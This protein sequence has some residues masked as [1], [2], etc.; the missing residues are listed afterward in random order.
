MGP[1][2]SLLPTCSSYLFP[3]QAG[4]H[5]P[6]LL[7]FRVSQVP[8]HSFGTRRLLP[9]RRVHFGVSV[10]FFPRDSG[11]ILCR[12]LTT[13]AFPFEAVS[14]FAFATPLTFASRAHSTFVTRRSSPSH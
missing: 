11:F 13:L 6:Y 5:F 1:S 2:D 4:A 9:P 8:G 3:A 7:D 12:S 10:S 14:D